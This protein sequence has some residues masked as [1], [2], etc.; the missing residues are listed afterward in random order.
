[1]IMI[2]K[3]DNQGKEKEGVLE[4]IDGLRTESIEICARTRVEH[5]LSV[6]FK[7]MLFI[8]SLALAYWPL[9]LWCHV[10]CAARQNDSSFLNFILVVQVLD[11]SIYAIAIV[12]IHQVHLTHTH[13][14]TI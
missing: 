13:F 2:R 11:G 12:I 5:K 4:A 10:K 3:P 8:F 1:M 14:L 9:L 7:F 6:C